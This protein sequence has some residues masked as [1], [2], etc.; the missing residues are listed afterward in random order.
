HRRPILGGH[1]GPHDRP[2]RPRGGD[3]RSDRAG[4]RQRGS[5]HRHREAHNRGR[6][7]RGRARFPSAAVAAQVGAVHLRRYG[8]VRQAGVIRGSRGGDRV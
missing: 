5:A 6:R 4:T 3:G 1:T 2:C 7:R 8:Q